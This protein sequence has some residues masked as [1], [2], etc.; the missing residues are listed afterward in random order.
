MASVVFAAS[1]IFNF[2][3]PADLPESTIESQSIPNES[4]IPALIVYIAKQNHVDPALALN[5]ACAESCMYDELD[6][7]VF[8]PKAKNPTSSASG[9]FQFIN[10]SW[11]TYCDGDV[12]DA[13][14]NVTCAISLLSEKGGISHWS[15]SKYDGFGGGWANEPYIKTK[16]SIK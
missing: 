6:N 15:A 3:Y 16:K 14:D 10:G 2:T 9:V 1:V 8:N 12:F 13:K 7:I 4:D 11:K 5:I